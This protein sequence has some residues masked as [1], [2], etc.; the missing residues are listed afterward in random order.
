[1][2]RA[3]GGVL[4]ARADTLLAKLRDET[5]DNVMP[6]RRSRGKMLV[7]PNRATQLQEDVFVA[8]ILHQLRN[9]HHGYELEEHGQRDL[10]DAHTGHVSSAF[11]EL[12][13]LY[14]VALLAQPARALSGA[15][16]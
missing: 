4:H 14:V 12:V 7:G 11:P 8:K 2:P 16:F 5:L 15:W 9:T 6:T 3:I 1:M 10:L 13:V